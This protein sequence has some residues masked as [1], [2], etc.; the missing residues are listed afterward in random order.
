M[1]S[2]GVNTASRLSA[3]DRDRALARLRSLT[4]GT[5]LAS[6]AAVGAFGM[7][8]PRQSWGH[9]AR[10]DDS[11]ATTTGTSSSGS[12]SSGSSSNGSS[13]NGS[14]STSNDTSTQ[15]SGG[16]TLKAAPT[17]ATTTR[18]HGQVTTGGS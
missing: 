1:D 3:A 17:P 14:S 13:S 4:I 9:L 11:G 2:P 6:V 12:S 10:L 5:T 7:S 18:H 8:G 16:S 15:S